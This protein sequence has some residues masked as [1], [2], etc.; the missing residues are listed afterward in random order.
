MANELFSNFPEIQ[1]TL[2][3]GKV[4]TIKDFFRKSTIEKSAVNSIVEYTYYEL[5]EGDRPDVVASKLYGDGDLHWTF[6][7]VNELENYYDWHMDSQIF[8]KYLEAK[9]K[10]QT[11]FS[12]NTQGIITKKNF[13]SGLDDSDGK[14]TYIE[15]VSITSSTK[16]LVGEEITDSA[17]VKLGQVINVNPTQKSI[18]VEGSKFAIGDVVTGSNSGQSF[19]VDTAADHRDTTSYYENVD[20]VKRNHGGTGWSEIS[21]YTE[22][23]NLNEAKRRIKI[24]RPEKIKRVVSEFER[25]MSNG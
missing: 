21:H 12:S 10:G 6:F 16:F 5:S 25:V 4:I 1:Y 9:F 7:L 2:N 17:G 20:K 14:F 22:E 15:D 24:I 3:T 11:L 13:K 19:T 23:W 8:E 18:T